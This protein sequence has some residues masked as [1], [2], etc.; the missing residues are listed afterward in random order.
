MSATIEMQATG[1]PAPAVFKEHVEWVSA[2]CQGFLDWQRRTILQGDP[3]AELRSTHREALKCLLRMT[4]SLYLTVSDPDYSDE[5]A[6][7]ELRGRLGQLEESWRMSN[8][9]MTDQAADEVLA[10]CFPG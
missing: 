2:Q 8:N 7:R 5:W 9:P 6:S 3:S 1:F 4:R 10:K